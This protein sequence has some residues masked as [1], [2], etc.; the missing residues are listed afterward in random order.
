MRWKSRLTSFCQFF[1]RRRQ[2]EDELDE[3]LR[4]FFDM[5]VDRYLGRGMTR[6]AALRQA[7]L[8]FEGVEQVRQKVREGFVGFNL[9]NLLQ[10]VR[11]A[12]RALRKSPSFAAVAVI[13][14]ALG[15]GV[16][17]A[18]FSVLYAVLLRP[19]PFDRP[20]QLV[21]LWSN[22]QKTAAYKAP[23]S[24]PILGE[25]EHR[26]RA[27]QQ[28]AGIWVGTGTFTGDQDPEQ[29]KLAQ[30][31]TNFFQTLGV[32]FALGRPFAKDDAPGERPA[33]ILSD[34]LWRRRFAADP[35]IVGKGVPFQGV[36]AT[37]VGVLPQN[38]Q[39]AFPP[40]SNV[41]ADVQA[42]VPFG[43]IY[44][45]P[46]TL[47]YIRVLA[48]LKPG[49]PMQQAQQ[50]LERVAQEIRGAY[51]EFASE[52]LT[53]TMTGM[54]ADAIRDIRP[55]VIA[56]F[57]GAAFVLLICCANVT[58]L[59]LARASDRRKEVAV[60]SAMGASRLRIL[61]QLLTEG[62]V[63][64]SIAGAFGLALAWACTRALVRLGPERL[65]RVGGIGLN[66]PVLLFTAVVSL[67]AVTVFGLA[68]ALET[69]KLNLSQTIH[70]GGNSGDVPWRR[71]FGAALIVAEITTG[72][73]LVIGGGLMM[74]TLAKVEQVRP[75]FEPRSLLTFQAGLGRAPNPGAV[76]VREKE[77]E[78]KLASLP[79]V[80]KV[81]G[82]SHL[83]LDDYPNWYSSYRLEG[84]STNDA[85]TTPADYRSVTPGYLDAMGVRLLE[86]RYFDDQD[87]AGGRMV[88]IVDE[89]LAH[90][91]WPGQNAIGKKIEA[92]HVTAQGFV[93]VWSEVV[94]VVEHVHNHSLTKQ[95]RGEIYLPFEQS[96]RGPL[97]YVLRT[98]V[99][100]LSLVPD[101][102]RELRA[103]SPASALAKVRPMTTYMRQEIAPVG[104][105]A[106]LAGVFAG[107]AL[108][109]A[110]VGIYGVL[111][112]QVSRR[113]HEMGVRMALGADR[114]DV[115]RLVMG[116]GL[117]LTGLGLI[118][119]VAGAA[120]ASHYLRA[121]IYGVSPTD[122]ATYAVALL[123]LPAAA[124]L[125]CW[126]PASR[127][128]G[129]NPVDA[130][131][132]D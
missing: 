108:L 46:R 54:Q 29:V 106:V 67:A 129:A 121:L 116:E 113:M 37:V 132:T 66:W 82:V 28:V 70:Q 63:L 23:T 16:N 9:R 64:C 59:L 95:V 20:D 55:G 65:T 21:L 77:W 25:L 31:T 60:R 131:R 80:E 79:G 48:R 43:N 8:E 32:R 83:P 92:E 107:L 114:R 33:L 17:T 27:L 87:R 90:T 101:V 74:R 58:N 41:P 13:T 94:G 100:P 19:L 105:L 4:S 3:E 73:V 6:E 78:S 7:R 11:Y 35:N 124:L 125:G 93:P 53:F 22:F 30:V 119:G 127:A 84:M 104:F 128:A 40:E 50:D 44:R 96:P 111:Y 99:E 123:L 98:R 110:A 34:G 62:L 89:L 122:P 112:Y 91:A 97:S 102:R 69:L 36:N 118:L 26:N 68:P 24:G 115:L 14:L 130:I 56:L 45:G 42:F 52:N 51:T 5:L 85:S 126:R 57:G 1:F 38:F 15:I 10:D 103:I 76:L 72:F 49:I 47:Y 88:A 86:G 2:L 18:V 12:C 75:G 39:L 117:A 109:L 61:S 81:G 120:V 71:R